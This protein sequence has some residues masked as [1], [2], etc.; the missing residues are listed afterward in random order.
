MTVQTTGTDR[1][2]SFDEPE[3]SGGPC[4][5]DLAT[6]G[7]YVALFAD[8]VCLDIVVDEAKGRAISE[9][10]VI[11]PRG[12]SRLSREQLAT[13]LVKVGPVYPAG[14][15]AGGWGLGS[16][17]SSPWVIG[18]AVATAVAVPVAVHNTQDSSSSGS[19]GTTTRRRRRRQR[20]VSP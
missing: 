13:H 4:T 3:G 1:L 14:G 11:V 6:P 17:L 8:R 16:L 20:V 18:G 7:R 2:G 19:D 9:F 5:L 15:Q 12:K 10:K